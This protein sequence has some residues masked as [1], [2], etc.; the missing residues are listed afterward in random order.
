MAKHR[1]KW[2]PFYSW[3]CNEKC[4]LFGQRAVF[5]PL[6]KRK[7]IIGLHGEIFQKDGESIWINC[8]KPAVANL[9]LPTRLKVYGVSESIFY[10]PKQE[11]EK[12]IR[13]LKV[14]ST[15]ESQVNYANRCMKWK[16]MNQGGYFESNRRLW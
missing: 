11:L 10:R 8:W 16:P 6:L 1:R 13:V 9:H 2:R 15:R 14:P 5:N 12:W 4:F 7:S 3:R